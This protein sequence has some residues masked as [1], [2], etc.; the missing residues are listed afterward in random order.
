MY[1]S[2]VTSFLLSGLGSQQA[3]GMCTFPFKHRDGTPRQYRPGDEVSELR[4]VK[5]GY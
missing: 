2:R 1:V 3:H 4:L 5:R